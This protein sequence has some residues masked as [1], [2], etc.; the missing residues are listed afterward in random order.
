[1]FRNNLLDIKRDP[2]LYGCHS[3]RRGEAQWL[4]REKEWSIPRICDWGGWA[5]DFNHATI[6]KYLYSWNDDSQEAREDFFS[7]KKRLGAAR[8]QRLCPHCAKGCWCLVPIIIV[9]QMFQAQCS[10]SQFCFSFPSGYLT[11]RNFYAGMVSCNS[12]WHWGHCFVMSV[13]C[14][15]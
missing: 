6:L 1:M 14:P 3:C 10:D 9:P 15:S 2:W 8:P 12:S 7:P 13:D 4:A 5:L 11:S